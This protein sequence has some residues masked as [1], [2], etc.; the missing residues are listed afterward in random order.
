MRRDQLPEHS[1]PTYVM[2]RH[3]AVYIAV[4]KAACTSLKW[5]VA[6]VQ[7]EDP[8]KFRDVSRMVTRDLGIH[9]RRGWQ[10]TPM[11]H[12]LSDAELSEIA[13]EN[14][15]FIFTVVRHPS[16]RMFSAWQS[17]LLLRE[18]R[19][20]RKQG[21]AD[22]FPRIP[23]TSEEVVEDF[24]RFALAMAAEPDHPVMQDRHFMPQW[25]EAAPDR[26]PYT[27]IYRTSEIPQLLDELEQHLRANGY[28]GGEL[29]LKESNE[30]PLKPIAAVFPPD[31]AAAMR[32]I[33]ADDFAGLGY[34]DAVPPGLAPDESFP[35]GAL[36]EV[37][38]LIERHERIGDLAELAIG[39]E[40]QL[41]A[42]RK[43]APASRQPR[44]VAARIRRRFAAVLPRW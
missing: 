30:T 38:R 5:L 40:Q 18:P 24:R 10:R 33:F 43:P 44:R 4:S 1:R 28:E 12:S 15:W 34:D 16:A 9:L 29:Q 6:D 8:A 7:G 36:A 41:A 23:R 25:R 37:R 32:E 39:L 21:D 26:V 31:V 11:L 42:A 17:K 3:K 19:W 2:R 13:P 27:R 20:V 35:D 14:G 22:W